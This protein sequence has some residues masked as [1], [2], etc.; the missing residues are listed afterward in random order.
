MAYTIYEYVDS[1]VGEG[2]EPP[3]LRTATKAF[4]AAHVCQVDTKFVVVVPD[5][6]MH[7][8]ISAAGSA[9]TAADLAIRAGDRRGFHINKG[10]QAQLY[11]IASTVFA[12][13]PLPVGTSGVGCVATASFT[14]TAVAYGAGDIFD[15][16]REFAFTYAA[17]G[18]AIPTGSLIRILDTI[19]RIDATGLQSGEGAYVLKPYSATQPSAQADNDTWTLASGDLPSYRGSISLGT[20]VDEGGA[21][22]IK[23]SNIDTDI[24]LSTSSLWG[25]LVTT[26]AFTP[27][28]VAR[29]VRLYAIVL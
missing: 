17:S 6:D 26:P 3:I 18:L 22:Y 15:V 10:S 1:Y 24:Q 8:R 16:S 9:A 28:A 4:G 20:P 5:A 12:T 29:Q 11:G 19:I 2:I 14:P 21:L 27:T 13:N 23:Q 7:L 25:R